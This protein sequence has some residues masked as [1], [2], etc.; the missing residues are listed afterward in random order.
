MSLSWF[1]RTTATNINLRLIC[2][3]KQ[4][5]NKVN[6]A[7]RHVWSLMETGASCTKTHG[8]ST[9]CFAHATQVDSTAN[10]KVINANTRWKWCRM[11][12]VS[13]SVKQY[14]MVTKETNFNYKDQNFI[15]PEL[16]RQRDDGGWSTEVLLWGLLTE[17][18]WGFCR[19]VLIHISKIHVWNNNEIPLLWILQEH[20]IWRKVCGEEIGVMFS[21]S[22]C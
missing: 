19:H 5:I 9:A 17:L 10:R 6:N 20:K 22:S 2:I 1:I 18:T 3:T 16:W 7:W 12:D 13:T 21:T 4:A 11:K 14:V 8:I 15:S